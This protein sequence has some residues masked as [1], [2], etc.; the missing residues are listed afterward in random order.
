MDIPID[1]SYQIPPFARFSLRKIAVGDR[2]NP[3]ENAQNGNFDRE[4]GSFL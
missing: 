1:L 2:Q 4:E 3:S